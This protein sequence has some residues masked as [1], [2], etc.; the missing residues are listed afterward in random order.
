MRSRKN[1]CTISCREVHN[2][3]GAVVQQHL[4]LQDPGYKCRLSVSND[5]EK[6]AA[7]SARLVT[8]GRMHH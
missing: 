8:R 2:R 6:K 3:A 7:P 4:Q 1:H 5:V